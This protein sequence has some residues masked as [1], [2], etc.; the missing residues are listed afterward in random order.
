M[1][2]RPLNIALILSLVILFHVVNVVHKESHHIPYFLLL[3]SSPF[4]HSIRKHL[5]I[6]LQTIAASACTFSEVHSLYS[7]LIYNLLLLIWLVHVK[8]ARVGADNATIRFELLLCHVKKIIQVSCILLSQTQSVHLHWYNCNLVSCERYVM[9]RCSSLGLRVSFL[10][11]SHENPHHKLPQR[12]RGQRNEAKMNLEYFSPIR[13]RPRPA[14]VI[15]LTFLLVLYREIKRRFYPYPRPFGKTGWGDAIARS[16]PSSPPYY[17]TGS[18]A[19][20]T[21]ALLFGGRT[22]ITSF[23]KGQRL[24]D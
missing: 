23:L 19:S 1:E 6:H 15:S 14:A 9:D 21:H 3:H 18:S 5:Q 22:F 17:C 16:L 11:S 7:S 20:I 4:D 12:G 8:E 2:C 24:E 10:H 13:P